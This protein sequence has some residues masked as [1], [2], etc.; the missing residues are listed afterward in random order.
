MRYSIIKTVLWQETDGEIVIV[1]PKQ[2]PAYLNESGSDIWKLIN[3]GFDITKIIETLSKEY[4]E[5]IS[6][7]EKDVKCIIKELLDNKYIKI[8]K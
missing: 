1:A 6:I 7:V 3:K 5:D 4:K 8:V 2:D